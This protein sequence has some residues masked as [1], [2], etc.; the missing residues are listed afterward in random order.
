MRLRTCADADSDGCNIGVR[1][2]TMPGQCWAGCDAVRVIR[3][4][5]ER[6]PTIWTLLAIIFILFKTVVAEPT[7]P[8]DVAPQQIDELFSAYNGPHSPGCSVGVIRNNSFIFQK[9]YGQASLEFNVPLTS[10]SVFYM[11]SVSKQ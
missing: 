4:F 11:A 10:K 2:A 1:G 9:S 5:G 8:K 6:M 3:T 7:R